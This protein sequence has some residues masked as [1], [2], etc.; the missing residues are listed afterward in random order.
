MSYS[1]KDT[2]KSLQ[3][4][5]SVSFY[6]A[7][8]QFLKNDHHTFVVQ[9]TEKLASAVYVVSGFMPQED[10]LRVR[11]RNAVVELV[12]LSVQ[13]Q[14]DSL[15]EGVHTRFSAQCMEIGAILTLGEKAGFIS[16][17][18][19]KILCDEYSSL[20]SFVRSH[21]D[22]V[23]GGEELDRE[24]AQ[25]TVRPTLPYKT[26]VNKGQNE[27]AIKDKKEET[28]TKVKDKKSDRKARIL[29]LL[30]IKDKIN[31]KDASDAIPECSEKTVQRE[32][33]DLV[34]EGVLIKEG[35]RRWSTYRRAF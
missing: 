14:H 22:K 24:V 10:P 33:N 13:P 26:K 34:Q 32:L 30:N 29:E 15:S 20:A 12:T 2:N 25:P 19:S 7:L 23:F 28:K 16:P 27:E 8:G 11:L 31:V 18:N 9:K 4:K 21:A 6:N 5:N 17:M 1:E 35:E 3:T